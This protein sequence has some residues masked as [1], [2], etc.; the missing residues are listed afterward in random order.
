MKASP[1]LSNDAT[2]AVIILQVR[3]TADS[4]GRMR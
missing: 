1:Q 4:P 2:R 3:F